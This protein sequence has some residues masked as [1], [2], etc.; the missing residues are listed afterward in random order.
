MLGEEIPRLFTKLFTEAERILS[1][2]ADL[3]TKIGGNGDVKIFMNKSKIVS[4]F[5][6]KKSESNADRTESRNTLFGSLNFHSKF[7]RKKQKK[8]R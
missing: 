1:E 6:K 7:S 8:I 2:N 5:R 4:T 3:F